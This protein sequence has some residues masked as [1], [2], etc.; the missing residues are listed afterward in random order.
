MQLRDATYLEV[1]YELARRGYTLADIARSLETSRQHVGW[2]LQKFMHSDIPPKRPLG[3]AIL[4]HIEL[5][6]KQP[7][8]SNDR[9]IIKRTTPVCHDIC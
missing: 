7:L 6:L 2:I 5:A 4:R 9:T 8:E 3:H 1:L